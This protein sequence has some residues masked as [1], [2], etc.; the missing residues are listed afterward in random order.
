[1]H[2]TLD[3]IATV[4]IAANVLADGPK[5]LKTLIDETGIKSRRLRRILDD[6]PIFTKTDDGKRALKADASFDGWIESLS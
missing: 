5:P 6:T 1:M 3:N 2:I 4:E